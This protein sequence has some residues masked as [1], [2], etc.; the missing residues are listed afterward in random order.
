MN[1]AESNILPFSLYKQLLLPDLL[2]DNLSNHQWHFQLDC[3]SIFVTDQAYLFQIILHTIWE[4][5]FY[6]HQKCVS[7]K[8]N[9]CGLASWKQKMQQV[10]SKP[11]L[12]CC[13]KALFNAWTIDLFL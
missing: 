6:V 4:L 5:I 7:A 2:Q 1:T 12:S 9:Y 3:S 13:F 8:S 11:L 10:Q